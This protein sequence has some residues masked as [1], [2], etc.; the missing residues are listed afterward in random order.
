MK[1]KTAKQGKAD[2]PKKKPFGSHTGFG[3]EMR[4]G[5]AATKKKGKK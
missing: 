3:E 1:K 5:H 4:E 2:A